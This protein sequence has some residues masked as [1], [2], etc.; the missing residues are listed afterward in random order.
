MLTFFFLALHILT[1]VQHFHGAPIFPVQH[2]Q[3]R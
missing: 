2:Y 3:S 1:P